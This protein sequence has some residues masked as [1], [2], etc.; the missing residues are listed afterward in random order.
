M[1]LMTKAILNKIPKLYAQDGKGDDAIVHVKFFY[2]AGR[3]TWY[4]TE[5]DGNDIF[6]GYVLGNSPED[7]E[8]GYFSL[9]ELQ[10]VRGKFGLG[11]ERDMYFGTKT[12]G[13]VKAEI[14]K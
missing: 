3:R 10:S 9:S 5:F 1:K 11:I 12:L 4:A 8:L 6:F 2:P 14:S 7:D 13:E